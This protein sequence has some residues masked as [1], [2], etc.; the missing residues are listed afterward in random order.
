MKL[1]DLKT[2]RGVVWVGG[3]TFP[4]FLGVF[5]KWLGEGKC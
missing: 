4:V 3:C 1:S 5:V 2:Q